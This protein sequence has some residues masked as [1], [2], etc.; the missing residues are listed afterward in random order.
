MI[1]ESGLFWLGFA[2]SVAPKL[3]LWEGEPLVQD[4]LT[5]RGLRDFLRDSTVRI[6]DFP[7]KKGILGGVSSYPVLRAVGHPAKVQSL[8]FVLTEFHC[9][10]F[11]LLLQF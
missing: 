10:F 5:H 9:I 3:L 2:H 6:R 11:K 4:A 7:W 8:S 1:E